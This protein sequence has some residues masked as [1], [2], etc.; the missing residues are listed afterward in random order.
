[1]ARKLW[2][3]VVAA[4]VVLLLLTGAARGDEPRPTAQRLPPGSVITLPDGSGETVIYDERYLIPAHEVD[5]ANAM[6]PRLAACQEDLTKVRVQLDNVEKPE[7][8]WKTY[9]KGG[10]VGTLI[11]GAFFA[12]YQLGR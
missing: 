7:S 6:V 5:R 4:V 3:Q 10:L 9:L 11:A 1:M 2:R 12:G 8:R